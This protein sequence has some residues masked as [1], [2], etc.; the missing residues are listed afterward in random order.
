M[1]VAGA[2]WSLDSA[3]AHR[4]HFPA[5][6]PRLSYSL[7]HDQL[8]GFFAAEAAADWT[9]NA[10]EAMALLQK[11]EE[12]QEVVQ[13]VGIES[14]PD[15][16]RIVLES[17]KMIRESYL[18]QNA[19]HEDDAFCTLSRQYGM[20]ALILHLHRRL[21]GALDGGLALEDILGLPLREEVATM[22]N[23]PRE[24]TDEALEGLR[25]RLDALI[26]EGLRK[27]ESPGEEGD[28]S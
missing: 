2:L 9:P 28:E 19:F 26:D 8:R 4:R 17:G 12:L 20:L 11:E 15:S 22:R 14:L 24:G 3:L 21:L 10:F 13:L 6:N 25:R 27:A 23:L 18:A 7:Y 1:R 16:E 5:V